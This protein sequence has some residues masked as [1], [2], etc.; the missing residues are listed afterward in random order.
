MVGKVGV[1]DEPDDSDDQLR[2][3]LDAQLT[4]EERSALTAR[5]YAISA[6]PADEELPP[7]IPGM[8]WPPPVYR[9]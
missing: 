8:Q 9:P 3:K 6:V 4:L 7:E 5:G 2:A 1:T